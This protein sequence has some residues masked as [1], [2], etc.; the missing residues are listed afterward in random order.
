[1]LG[2]PYDDT[3]CVLNSVSRCIKPHESMY[4]FKPGNSALHGCLPASRA[5]YILSVVPK[6]HGAE[7]HIRFYVTSPLKTGS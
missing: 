7:H 1:M 5:R 4:L 3:Q 2:D 6:L